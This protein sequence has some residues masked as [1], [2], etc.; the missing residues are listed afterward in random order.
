VRSIPSR[1]MGHRAADRIISARPVS[2]AMSTPLWCLTVR[3]K[4]PSPAS[5]GTFGMDGI[6]VGWYNGQPDHR[7]QDIDLTGSRAVIIG[8]GDIVL[9]SVEYRS[10]ILVPWPAPLAPRGRRNR[11][12]P[13]EVRG[14]RRNAHRRSMIHSPRSWDHARRR[15]RYVRV[16]PSEGLS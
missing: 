8:N 10:A 5:G 11:P 12:A 9:I 13:D 7:S 16:P 4:P 3:S 1:Q 6:L 14:Y 15:G 2:Q